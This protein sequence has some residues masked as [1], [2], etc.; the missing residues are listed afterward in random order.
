M[1]STENYLLKL[2]SSNDVTFF[3]P[4]YQRN[5]EWDKSQCEVFFNDITKTTLENCKGTLAEHFFGTVVYVQDEAAFGQPNKLI[6]T[7]GQQRITT[8]MLFLIAAREAI[9]DKSTKHFID[10]KYLKNANV[11][12]EMEYKIKLKQVETD[13]EAYRN[14][15]LSYDL[16]EENKKSSIYQNYQYFK[17]QL[18][19]FKNQTEIKIEDLISKGLDKF[20]IVTIQLEPEK[21][22]WEN[23]QEVFESMNSLG[24]PL[25]LA[26]L[27]R[28]YLLLGKNAK[29][30][31]MLYHDYWLIIEKR[32]PNQVSN[33]IRDY[34][35]FTK[36]S[37]YKKANP[38]N[39]KELYSDF[40][41]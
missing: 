38:N 10:S 40:K 18:L 17:T 28:N 31:D 20:S 7:D 13:W 5:Y 16:T 29:E 4:P 35:Q 41:N 23:P 33:F 19:S 39:Y 37:D 30:Q 9:D 27:V 34:M 21:N 3:I 25:S 26:D 6:L 2:L 11:G 1:K 15:V 24:K 14:I 12:G 22:R 32:L 36:G 8:T